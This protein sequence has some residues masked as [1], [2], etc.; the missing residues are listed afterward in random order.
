MA[1]ILIRFGEIANAL[2]S[3]AKNHILGITDDIYDKD[4][5]QYQSGYNKKL[6]PLVADG[7]HLPRYEVIEKVEGG[8]NGIPNTVKY[9]PNIVLVTP[10]E[11]AVIETKR[12]NVLYLLYGH[13]EVAPGEFNEEEFS[14]IAAYYNEAKLESEISKWTIEQIEG[15][16]EIIDTVNDAISWYEN[17]DENV[18]QP[19]IDELD[20]YKEGISE[21]INSFVDDIDVIKVNFS[22]LE[23][24]NISYIGWVN[25]DLNSDTFDEDLDD[26]MQSELDNKSG[27][28]YVGTDP[29]ALAVYFYNR[30]R[31][32]ATRI[33]DKT[34]DI[35]SNIDQFISDMTEDEYNLLE[36][37]DP[38]KYYFLY[39]DE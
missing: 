29:T 7:I 1:D 16:H 20:T 31:R 22:N 24:E 17:F 11:Y 28:F 35:T 27:W 15:I 6:A 18:F 9:D 5:K 21:T 26:R 10:E 32:I 30:R 13:P 39:E 34:Y 23:F 2:K 3:V 33:N 38:K 25:V 12:K 4:L 19:V 8:V 36:E 14:I 37:K